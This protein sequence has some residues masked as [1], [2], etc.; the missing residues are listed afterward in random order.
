MMRSVNVLSRIE[1]TVLALLVGMG[2]LSAQKL[3]LA[4]SVKCWEN[5]QVYNQLYKSKQYNEAYDAW[6]TVYDLCPGKTKNTFIYGPTIVEARIAKT[7]DAAAKEALVQILLESYDKRLEYFPEKTGFVLSSKAVSLQKYKPDQVKEAHALYM[8]AYEA[9]GYDLPAAAF[10][11]MF[12]TGAQLYNSK[13]YNIN[14]VFEVYNLVSEAIEKNNNKLNTELQVFTDK[15]EQGG[16]LDEKEQKDTARLGR[17]LSRYTVVDQNI[18]KTL[19][20]IATC[21]KLKLLYDDASFEANKENPDWLRRAAKMLQKERVNAEGDVED[22]TELPIFF[23][24]AEANYRLE[25]SAVSARAVGKLAWSRKDYAKAVEYFEEASRR[26]IDPVKKADDH[27]KIAIS[28]QRR[29]NPSAAK[30]SAL[31][32]AALRKNWGE[33]YVLIATLYGSAEGNC[34]GANVVE[35][36]AVYW[37]AMDKLNYAKSIDPSVANKC[38]RLISSYQA[39]LP[40]KS[41]GFQL[42]VKDGDRISIG[43][44]INEIVTVRF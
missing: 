11:G 38:N 21:E 39:Q 44:W 16:V 33:P 28:H 35:N 25:P 12:M 10:N 18:E 4:D 2:T 40:Q 43:C 27:L 24:I 42:G 13:D 19:G 26:E 32:A 6:K 37:A 20:P 22:C 23:K 41:I 9:D 29:G 34:G 14:Q 30:A 5:T 1:T 3:S 15:I 36:K 31:K 8:K 7:T 17:E